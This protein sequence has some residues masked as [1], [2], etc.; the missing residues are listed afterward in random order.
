M[1]A[2]PSATGSKAI[3]ASQPDALMSLPTITDIFAAL[4]R[5]F[6]LSPRESQVRLAQRVRDA[7]SSGGVCCVE[8]PTGTGKTLGY[9]A[10][11][12]DAYVHAG[13]PVPVVVATA[14]VGLQE[15]ILRDDIPRLA[16]VGAIDPRR[17]AV[18]KGR[19]RYFCPR[20]AALLED[21]KMQDSQLDMLDTEKP[22]A[23]AG[24]PIALDMLKAW[25]S[26]AWDGD[27]DTWNGA[28][29]GCWEASCGA[30]SETCVNRA[31][32]HF[33]NCPYMASRARLATAQLIIANQ[34]MVL[35]D[36]AQRADEQVGTALP[37]KRYALVVDEAHNLPD[38][39]V[40]TR[41][42]RAMLS[43]T[44]WLRKLET[45]GDLCLNN[46]IVSAALKR[47]DGVTVDA[48]GADTAHLF[49]GMATLAAELDTLPFQ[50]SGLHSWGLAAPAQALLSDVSDLTG[51]ALA[52]LRALK[53]TAKAFADMAEE[54]AG[55]DKGFAIRMLTQT[56]QYQ[57]R[58]KELYDGLYLFCTGDKLVRWASRSRDGRLSLHTQPLE[59]QTV[60]NEL[61]WSAE[62]PVAMVSATLQINGSFKRFSDKS[63]LPGRA[64]TEILPPVFD[65]SRGFFHQPSMTYE[66]GEP[67]YEAELADKI[68]RLFNKN[69]A[70]GVLTLFTSREVMRRVMR[71]VS[72]EVGRHV[73]VQDHRPLPELIAQ[74]KERIDRGE[75]SMLVGLQ[76]MAEGLDLP[77]KYCGHVIMTR[78]PFN[79]P[80]DPVEEARRASMGP[81]WFN[82]AYLADMLTML[83]QSCGRLIRR[84]SDHGVISVLDKR[85][86]AKRYAKQ[87]VDAL[88]GFTRG[89][90]IDDY[91]KM[92]RE[93][94]FDLL[95]GVVR[96][97]GAV[98]TQ[99]TAKLSV[100]TTTATPPRA[101]QAALPTQAHAAALKESVDTSYPEQALRRLTS[102]PATTHGAVSCTTET[103][104]AGLNEVLPV[105][106]GPFADHETPYLGD[107]N[108]PP[109]LPAGT[110]AMVWAERQLPQAVMLGLRMRNLAWDASAQEWLQ[111]LRL[112]PDLVQYAEV[113]RAHRQGLADP[114][115]SVLSSV[116]CEQQLERGLN[117]LDYPGE[118][119]LFAALAQMEAEV[120]NI[121]S[122][123]HVVPRRD[124]LIELTQAARAV[125]RALVIVPF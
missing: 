116:Q 27:R 46:T 42:A 13:T 73:L 106:P 110:P 124:M 54:S 104:A 64:V 88:P 96:K 37:P 45:Y 105:M 7:I 35:A 66:P 39:A 34:D 12:I 92:A 18:A 117:S 80:G 98:V 31:C 60:L 22:V 28:I 108:T 103:L 63:G 5:K 24:V 26:K 125:A 4:T 89:T 33:D 102:G 74:H 16:A 114:R 8:A 91:F 9:L 58:A 49:G 43:D 86:A 56:Y 94:G 11:A 119:E 50:A 38:K 81:A 99:V 76:S 1:S 30:N 83:I 52:L 82:D 23:E 47:A 78:L 75:R 77:G 15:Q 57:R 85:L 95:H 55:S 112:R 87:A 19:G 32:E 101:E 84:E 29:P 21:R 115:C 44:D 109:C 40:S 36:L 20:T 93:R 111:V 25:R 72:P 3:S 97:V 17:V 2:L 90:R 41:Q 118:S 121:L 62:M 70:P 61:L 123:P 59:G 10:G 100:V 65:Y 68:E 6:G 107:E 67:G 51:R 53:V 120:V 71:S 79:V 113:L 48:F 14:T 122:G 69:V